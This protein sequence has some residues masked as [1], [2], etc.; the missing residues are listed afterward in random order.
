M[1]LKKAAFIGEKQLLMIIIILP[2]RNQVGKLTYNSVVSS[3]VGVPCC[4]PDEKSCFLRVFTLGGVLFSGRAEGGVMD[5]TGTSGVVGASPTILTWLGVAVTLT[6]RFAFS[7]VTT[8]ATGSSYLLVNKKSSQR[9]FVWAERHKHFY[10]NFR[11]QCRSWTWSNQ[12]DIHRS[13]TWCDISI[14]A[15]FCSAST[16]LLHGMIYRSQPVSLVHPLFHYM[17]WYFQAYRSRP[18]SLVHSVWKTVL[19]FLGQQFCSTRSWYAVDNN[20]Y[21]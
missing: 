17:I 9:D 18:V 1:N 21:K 12:I 7:A 11:R 4:E 15:C 16:A 14:S 5:S 3:V 19:D 13:I 10:Q 6:C 20:K 8:I 2:H